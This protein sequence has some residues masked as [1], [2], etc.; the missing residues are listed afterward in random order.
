M[1]INVVFENLIQKGPETSITQVIIMRSLAVFGLSTP[2]STG[3][4]SWCSSPGSSTT[5][6][7]TLW[8]LHMDLTALIQIFF[9]VMAEG[10]D[11]T[12]TMKVIPKFTSN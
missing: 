10:T 7:R 8:L 9:L 6:S 2:Y 11:A 3:T 12:E 5:H 1:R 4:F